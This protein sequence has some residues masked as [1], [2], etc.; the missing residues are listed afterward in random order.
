MPS[1]RCI[2]CCALRGE[3]YYPNRPGRLYC[4]AGMRPYADPAERAYYSIQIHPYNAREPNKCSWFK[5]DVDK[6]LLNLAEE[7]G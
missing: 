3:P 6:A 1:Q 4:T 7:G 2:D 5:L